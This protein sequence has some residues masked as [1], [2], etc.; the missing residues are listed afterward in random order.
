MALGE[1]IEESRGK[2]T[3]Q[4]FLEVVETPKTETSFVM[5]GYFRGIPSTNVGTYPSV[6]REGKVLYGEGQGVVAAK[7]GQGMA[8]WTG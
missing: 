1:Q 6:L 4:R 8:T 3:S 2:I 7:D 5:E